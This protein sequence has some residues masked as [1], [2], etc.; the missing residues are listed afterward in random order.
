MVD[1]RLHH[2]FANPE[3]P[4]VTTHVAASRRDEP[5]QR[6]RII[7]QQRSGETHVMPAVRMPITP[8]A[9]TM[10]QRHASWLPRMLPFAAWFVVILAAMLWR[11]VKSTGPLGAVVTIVWTY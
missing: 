9:A 11:S 5:G 7:P 1:H 8:S 10:A 4:S 2:R 6:A 3:G